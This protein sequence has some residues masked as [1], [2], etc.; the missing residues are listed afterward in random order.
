MA[1]APG[2]TE[3]QHPGSAHLELYNVLLLSTAGGSGL[4]HILSYRV[5]NKLHFLAVLPPTADSGAAPG[6]ASL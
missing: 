4:C 1:L 5:F 6:V 2:V 3:K